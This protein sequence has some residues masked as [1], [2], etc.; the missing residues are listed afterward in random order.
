VVA[1]LIGGGAGL[2]VAGAAAADG[3]GGGGGAAATFFLAQAVASRLIAA[4]AIKV[5]LGAWIMLV[6]SYLRLN[7]FPRA[8][9]IL[10]AQDF[11]P[12]PR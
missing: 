6:L 12:S 7:P 4:R 11:C 8:D 5:R 9:K 1:E 3:G 10:S 2:E